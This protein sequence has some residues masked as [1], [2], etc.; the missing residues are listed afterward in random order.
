MAE[1]NT[2]ELQSSTP[3][4]LKPFQ[5]SHSHMYF[6][7]RSQHHQKQKGATDAENVGR[8]SG[9]G[10]GATSNSNGYKR[11]QRAS[12]YGFFGFFS[13]NKTSDIEVSEPKLDVQFEQEED[14]D[15]IKRE[16]TNVSSTEPHVF[17]PQPDSEPVAETQNT[18]T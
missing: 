1:S 5:S 17:S 2:Q 15:E 10:I 9:N 7:Q 4:T 16:H 3:S 13:R 8:E 14:G 11:K 6:S 18:G 12:R